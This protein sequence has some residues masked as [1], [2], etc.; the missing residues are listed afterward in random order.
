[1]ALVDLFLLAEMTVWNVE[2]NNVSGINI[3]LAIGLAVDYSAHIAAAFLQFQEPMCHEDGTKLTD[4]E[5]RVCKT[6]GALET[7][8]TSVFHGAMSSF[9][10]V[11]SLTY[12]RSY[13]FE[14]FFKMMFG[15]VLFGLSNG[16]ILL[17][18]LLALTGPLKHYDDTESAEDLNDVEMQKYDTRNDN[19]QKLGKVAGSPSADVKPDSRQTCQMKMA[20]DDKEEL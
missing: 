3:V 13:I 8:G 11:V 10:A 19:S 7:M 18:V 6:K 5:R 14:T 15:I 9:L 16:F 12:A 17:P 1:M 2:Y 4:F 20:Q